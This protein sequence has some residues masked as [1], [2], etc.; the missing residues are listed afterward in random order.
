MLVAQLCLTLCDPVDCSLPGSSVHGKNNGVDCHS[1]PQ[2]TFPT[3]GSI[4]QLSC[5]AG[6]FF[7]NWATREAKLNPW[8]EPAP[9]VNQWGKNYRM[10]NRLL[11]TM[12]W[13]WREGLTTKEKNKGIFLDNGNV[14]CCGWGAR[15]DA[16]HLSKP[17][18]LCPT[19]QILLYTL[20][21]QNQPPP[22][23]LSRRVMV[24]PE[25]DMW[26]QISASQ[27]QELGSVSFNSSPKWGQWRLRYV[28]G[29]IDNIQAESLKRVLGQLFCKSIQIHSGFR[30][31]IF[32]FPLEHKSSLSWPLHL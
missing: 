12:S 23:R 32:F 9:H 7:T 21:K 13:W 14:L 3:Q 27:F 26:L 1:L 20:K 4:R 11:V 30:F 29:G 2:G 24:H 6:R 31:F 15:Y 8:S 17:I 10:E 19:E 25:D 28:S 18:E 22:T 5:T 16:M